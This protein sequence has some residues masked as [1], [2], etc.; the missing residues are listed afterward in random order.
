[1]QVCKGTTKEKGSSA[2][3]AASEMPPLTPVRVSPA[4]SASMAALL[5]TRAWPWQ[6][7]NGQY[8]WRLPLTVGSRLSRKE[9]L[10]PPVE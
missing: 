7:T 2:S 5:R 9:A 1:M 10:P 6:L 8:S 4:G 3:V